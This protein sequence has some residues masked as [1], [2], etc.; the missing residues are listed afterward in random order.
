MEER[1][2]RYVS[3]PE[4]DQVGRALLSWLNE[5]PEFPEYVRRIE[6]EYLSNSDSMGLFATSSAYKIEEYISGA[7]DAQYQFALQY[8]TTAN[9]TNKRLDA[10]E[11][12]S[13]IAAWAERRC[14]NPLDRPDLGLG[15]R[16]INV[17]RNSPAVM[18]SRYEDG[19]ED[20]QILMVMTYEVRN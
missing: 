7:Y 9:N 6:A 10:A 3:G 2:L 18:I 12:L 16:A 17:E 13:D 20:Y 15:K 14:E 19:K 1:E 8:R 4:Q 5:Y 11:A